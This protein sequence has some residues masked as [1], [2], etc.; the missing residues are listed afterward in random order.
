MVDPR[1]A[2]WELQL[3]DPLRNLS[4]IENVRKPYGTLTKKTLPPEKKLTPAQVGKLRADIMAKANR[5]AIR[6]A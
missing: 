6:G 5:T 3:L 1:V 2:F 4:K